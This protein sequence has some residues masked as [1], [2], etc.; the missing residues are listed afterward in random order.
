MRTERTAERPN[1]RTTRPDKGD[2]DVGA[3]IK[4]AETAAETT[5]ETT[6]ETVEVPN[7]HRFAI[8][9]ADGEKVRGYAASVSFNLADGEPVVSFGSPKDPTK[10]TGT[11]ATILTDGGIAR[12][13]KALGAKATKETVTRQAR[14]GSYSVK[15]SSAKAILTHLGIDPDS[16]SVTSDVRDAETF[17]A[18]CLAIIAGKDDGLGFVLLLPK[19]TSVLTASDTT[20]AARMEAFLDIT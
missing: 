9:T 14:Q 17:K 2:A 12:A 19:E 4:K 15:G 7:P 8:G 6:V 10:E 5:V 18:F 13:R 16:V 20:V 3:T 1:G 11:L